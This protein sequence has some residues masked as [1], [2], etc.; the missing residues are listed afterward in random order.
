MTGFWQGL[1]LECSALAL[2][3]PDGL[4]FTYAELAA[5]ADESAADLA[6]RTLVAIECGNE[7]SCVAAYIGCLRRGVVPLLIDAGLAPELRV[8]LYEHFRIQ[9]IW[10]KHGSTTRH[11]WLP[12]RHTSPALHPTLALLMLTS[13]STGA[14]Q[15]VRLSYRNLQC[16]AESIAQCLNISC[17]DR[18]ITTLPMH[19]SYGLS[20]INSHL[21]RRACV[22]LTSS[23]VAE[24]AFWDFFRRECATSLSGVPAIY[25]MLRR[26]RFERMSLPS[27][28]DMTQAGGHL[29][30]EQVQWFAQLAK[31][32][33]QRFIVM[34][35]QT[36]A[37][38]RM[39]FLPA[40]RVLEKKESVGLAIP[41]GEFFLRD[42]HNACFT[43][44][45]RVGELI[46]RGENVMLGYA[47][48]MADLA[49]GD[50]LAGELATGDMAKRDDDGFY[51]IVGRLKRFIKI[52]GNRISLDEVEQRLQ[53]SG[54]D[55][56]AI[57]RDDLLVIALIDSQWDSDVV[58]QELSSVYRLHHSVVRVFKC[59]NVPRSSSGKVQYQALL[60]CFES[61]RG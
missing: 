20:V 14:P 30:P 23:S 21:T 26:L 22:L 60:E 13:G 52:H 45:E 9:L 10:G 34:Y 4:A 5:Q 33:D 11:A 28:R 2:Q 38:A 12:L 43:E 54:V 46:D 39:S 50:S 17:R 7:V 29:A 35:G 36:E 42:S 48:V 37:T 44:A 58:A 59:S 15:L 57:G 47:E 6:P 55:A 27:L 49:L 51:Y 61:E 18:P 56:Y 1:E 40:H 41:G 32:R 31:S 8:K 24:R 19:Y 53:S 25:D 3:L 16:N